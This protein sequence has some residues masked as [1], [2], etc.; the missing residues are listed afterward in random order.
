MGAA[1]VD[2][3]GQTIWA[4]TLPPNTSVQKAELIALIQALE[5]AKGKRVTIFTDSRYAFS[6]AHIQG[7]IY[8]ERGFQTAEGKEV[9]N[10]PEIR[11]LLEPVQLPR[12]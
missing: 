3:S 10:L 5:K 1:I 9:K 2:D 8:Q 11:R 6:T 7:S 12:Q 4:K